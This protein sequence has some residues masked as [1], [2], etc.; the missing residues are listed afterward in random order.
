MSNLI[1]LNRVF[2]CERGGP[3]RE[4]FRLQFYIVERVRERAESRVWIGRWRP[5]SARSRN[6][7]PWSRARAAD[8]ILPATDSGYFLNYQE[9][10][11]MARLQIQL[12]CTHMDVWLKHKWSFKYALS[13]IENTLLYFFTRF[14]SLTFSGTSNIFLFLKLLKFSK[15]RKYYNSKYFSNKNDFESSW[16]KFLKINFF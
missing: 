15:F 16:I 1:I 11:V 10:S 5:T 9:I 8:T 13:F 7:P 4:V 12:F 6:T 3:V 2:L 14:Y